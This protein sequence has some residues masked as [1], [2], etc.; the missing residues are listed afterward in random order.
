MKKRGIE[1]ADVSHAVENGEILFE[2]HDRRFG[3][4]RYS[5]LRGFSRD[6]VVVWFVN[7]K[8]EKEVATTY[9]RRKTWEK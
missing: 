1:E 4:K 5:C 7:K 3:H 8:G 9:W 2:E 6:L